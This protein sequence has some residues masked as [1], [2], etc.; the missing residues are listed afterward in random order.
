MAITSTF[1]SSSGPVSRAKRAAAKPEHGQVAA[2]ECAT[3]PE[4]WDM[5]SAW[6]SFLFSFIIRE[7]SLY[8]V[9]T[10]ETDKMNN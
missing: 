5:L 2:R 3:Q 7:Y 1:A 10:K 9:F 6:D 8:L 4:V